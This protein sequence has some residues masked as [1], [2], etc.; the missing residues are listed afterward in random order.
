MQKLIIA[1]LLTIICI[2]AHAQKK[3]VPHETKKYEKRVV[4][5]VAD[6]QTLM[7]AVNQYKRLCVYDPAQ[8]G[9]EKVALIQNIETYTMALQNRIKIDSVVVVNKEQIP[10]P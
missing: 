5:E 7:Q 6:Y 3:D 9:D 8:N 10:K 2:S 4:L 1:L